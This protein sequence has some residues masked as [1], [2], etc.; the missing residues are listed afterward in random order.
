M[1]PRQESNLY[2]K[3]RRLTYY[4]LYYEAKKKPIVRPA[5]CSSGGWT[6]TNDL[7]VMSPTRYLLLHPALYGQNTYRSGAAN[8]I[9][10]TFNS[11]LIRPLCNIKPVLLIS[12][13]NQTPVNLPCLMPCS[14]KNS[15]SCLDALKPPDTAFLALSTMTITSLFFP[16][17]RG[18]LTPHTSSKKK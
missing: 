9:C 10:R 3:F 5:L 17:P 6:R 7:R 18:L 4:P 2:L 16:I 11:K 15:P 14:A 12:L 1:W 8:I 13:A